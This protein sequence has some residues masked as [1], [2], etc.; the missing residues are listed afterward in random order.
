VER[1]LTPQEI[2]RMQRGIRTEDEWLRLVSIQLAR[3][4]REGFQYVIV[5]SEGRNRHIRRMFEALQ[6]RVKRL[7]RVSFGPLR[8]GDLKAGAYRM[9]T[10]DEVALLKKPSRD[11]A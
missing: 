6:V 10:A 4:S 9:L 1:E 5:L 8:I 3:E 11:D 2:Q 7:K